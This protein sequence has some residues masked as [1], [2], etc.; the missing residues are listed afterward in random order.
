MSVS[1]RDNMCDREE[2][3]DESFV[4]MFVPIL[5]YVYMYIAVH[6]VKL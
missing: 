4:Y 3:E 6:N 1:E 5:Y 2:R